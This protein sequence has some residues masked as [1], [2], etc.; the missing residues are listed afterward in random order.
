MVKKK[1]ALLHRQSACDESSCVNNPIGAKWV[2][3][4]WCPHYLQAI[5]LGAS[6]VNFNK[7]W[8][9]VVILEE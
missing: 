8:N 6:L 4:H 1:K 3:I 2:I 7:C 9:V 5:I